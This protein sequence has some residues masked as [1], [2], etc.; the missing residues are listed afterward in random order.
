MAFRTNEYQ[1]MSMN[2]HLY[3]LTDRELRILKGSWAEEFANHIFPNLPEE[4]FSVLYS[5]ND[6]SKPNTPI[7]IILGLL[8]LK[9]QFDLT[10]EEL[11]QQLLFNI[12]FQYALHTSS[13]EEQPINDNTLRRFRNKVYEYE[14][15]TGNDLIKEAFKTLAKK[16]SGIMELKPS[17]GRVDSLMI[18]SG[19]RRLSR[20]HIMHETLRLVAH[21]LKKGGKETPI[22]E[23]YSDDTENKDIGYRLKNEDVMVRMEEMLRDAVALYEEYPEEFNKSEAFTALRRMIDDQSKMTDDGRILKTG[24][25]ISPESM[26][27]PHE[28]DATYRKKAGKGYVGFTG[29]IVEACDADKSLI[30]DYDLQKNTYSDTQFA[31]DML[32][33]MPDGDSETNTIVFDGAYVSTDTLDLAKTKNVEVVTTS[34]IGGLQGTF[35]AEF[36]IDGNGEIIKCPAGYSPNDSKHDNGYYQA[37]FNTEICENCEYCDRCP[38]IFQKNSALIKYSDTSL[39]RAMY[40]QQLGT[41]R[42]WE[43]IKKRNGIESVNSVLRRTYGIDRMREKGVVRKR[44]RLGLKLMAINAKRLYKWMKSMGKQSSVSSPFFE[45]WFSC[46]FFFKIKVASVFI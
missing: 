25:Q 42:Y 39:Q 22:S 45:I 11:M 41:G 8:I 38:G 4:P 15:L 14:K 30:M 16:T 33:A 37:H 34:L 26:Q 27:T 12:Q 35:E 23:K 9:D 19:C 13:F 31:E 6:A 20:L 24:K 21:Q 32:N 44:Q 2:D 29:N 5:A 1:Q 17:L 3:N 43:L 10:D 28:Q 7:N 46:P 18:S 40:E 36:E